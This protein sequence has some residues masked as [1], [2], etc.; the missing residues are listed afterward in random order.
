MELTCD[1]GCVI[2][3]E[4]RPGSIDSGD[5]R[6]WTI[7]DKIKLEN[8]SIPILECLLCKK[9]HVPACSFAG[10]N[11]LDNEIK[12]YRKILEVVKS[13]N[14]RIDNES[15]ILINNVHAIVDA[16]MACEID[17]TDEEVSVDK[18]SIVKVGRKPK[19][20]E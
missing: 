14:D 2:F 17:N 10:K 5:F 16:K 9:L 20:K 11:Q 19:A 13:H 18:D 6:V 12:Y 15:R 7:R 1:C 8:T 4:L 3:T